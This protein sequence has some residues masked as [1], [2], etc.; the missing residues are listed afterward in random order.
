MVGLGV[1]IID[2]SL[3]AG[4]LAVVGGVAGGAG[5]VAWGV[6]TGRGI[7]RICCN[8]FRGIDI[9]RAGGTATTHWGGNLE[10]HTQSQFLQSIANGRRS[11]TRVMPGATV[12][13]SSQ[14]LNL[15]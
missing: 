7:E 13:H 9:Q 8:G 2:P 14:C 6:G 4:T 5:D 12:C 11:R 10:L 1:G 3:G 15:Q